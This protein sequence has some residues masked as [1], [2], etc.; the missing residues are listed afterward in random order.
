MMTGLFRPLLF[1]LKASQYFVGSVGMGFTTTMEN[2]KKSLRKKWT[3][4]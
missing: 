3:I 2:N 1:P 4:L